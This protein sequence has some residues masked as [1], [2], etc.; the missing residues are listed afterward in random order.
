LIIVLLENGVSGFRNDDVAY[1]GTV[2]TT[3][4]TSTADPT[5]VIETGAVYRYRP[6]LVTL[7]NRISR[8]IDVGRPV[9][10]APVLINGETIEG[11]GDV[12]SSWAFFATGIYL[13]ADNEEIFAQ[14]RIYGVIEPVD[15]AAPGDEEDSDL[16]SY[17]PVTISQLVDVSGVTVL[18]NDDGSL[19]PDVSTGDL[20]EPISGTGEAETDAQLTEFIFN[21]SQGWFRDLPLGSGVVESPSSRIVD[22]IVP[23]RE[24]LFF[25]AFTPDPSDR[26]DICIGGEGLSELFVVDQANGVPAAFGTLGFGDDGEVNESVLIGDGVASAPVIF[27]SEALGAN[28]GTIIVQ[29]EDGS[30]TPL[31]EPEGLGSPGDGNPFDDT[32]IGTSETLRSSWFEIFQ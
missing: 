23:F 25:T 2:G 14:E 20:S 22:R 16:L 32:V 6:S 17:S 4:D 28:D 7:S 24:Q 1:F 13:N 8:L 21:N 26:L 15:S 27:T 31:F 11:E 9:V 10:Q 3:L 5:D 19:G 30:L 18:N 12:L 29:R